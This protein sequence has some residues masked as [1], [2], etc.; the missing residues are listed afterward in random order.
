M[1]PWAVC[2]IVVRTIAT[3]IT[4]T[5]TRLL[6]LVQSCPGLLTHLRHH[7]ESLIRIVHNDSHLVLRLHGCAWDEMSLVALDV[8]DVALAWVGALEYVV[9]NIVATSVAIIQ[10]GKLLLYVG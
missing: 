1:H 7:E 2:F 9:V 10:V 6:L 4:S 8:G 5:I 3:A